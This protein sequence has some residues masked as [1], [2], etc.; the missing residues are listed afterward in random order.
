MQTKARF[1]ND[2]LHPLGY[3]MLAR[4]KAGLAAENAS[5]A[6]NLGHGRPMDKNELESRKD[7]GDQRRGA[8]LLR[9]L[10]THP[11]PRPKRERSK[12][13]ETAPPHESG[14]KAG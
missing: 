13:K 11:Q 1:G 5:V 2:A 10:K 12:G 4:Q 9:L 6:T 7:D 3:D 14:P 8:L